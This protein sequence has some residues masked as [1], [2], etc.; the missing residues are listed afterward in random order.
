[1]T[2]SPKVVRLDPD[3]DSNTPTV[4]F[5]SAAK[6]PS[7]IHSIDILE[8]DIY[9]AQRQNRWGCAIVRAIQRQRPEATYVRVDSEEIAFSENGHRTYFSTPKSAIEKI[10]KPFDEGKEVKPTR[11]K[12]SSPV[13]VRP[14]QK[15]TPEKRIELRQATRVRQSREQA[16]PRDNTRKHN[17]FCDNPQDGETQQ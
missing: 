15:M 14:V 4:A 12:L 7:E 5:N 11:I 17:R 16:A 1:M 9:Y 2:N 6:S 8:E 3:A 13:E 10:I